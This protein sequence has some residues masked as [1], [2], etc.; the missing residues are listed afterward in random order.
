MGGAQPL[1]VTMCGGTALCIEVDLRRIERRL[2]TRYLDE[3][4]GDLDDALAR[5]KEAASEG[6]PLSIGL[7]GNAAEVIPEL[8]NSAL[9]LHITSGADDGPHGC[10]HV[11]SMNV[12]ENSLPTYGR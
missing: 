5:L 10:C 9:A 8:V 4:A 7:L 2:H 6:R 12:S 3:R 11:S 1:A